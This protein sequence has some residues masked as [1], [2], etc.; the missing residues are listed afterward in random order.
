MHQDISNSDRTPKETPS[1]FISNHSSVILL[2]SSQC[3]KM[4]CK[5][6][7]PSLNDEFRHSLDLFLMIYLIQSCIKSPVCFRMSRWGWWMTDVFISH[8]VYSLSF[9][10]DIE[11]LC[12]VSW[13][14]RRT[15]LWNCERDQA[16]SV[17]ICRSARS[18]LLRRERLASLSSTCVTPTSQSTFSCRE[19]C[20]Q[21]LWLHIVAHNC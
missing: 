19:Q 17:E 1:N 6:K 7:A 15:L 18:V 2:L 5:L 9:T 10:G 13:L 8:R 14:N 4:C 16:F 11:R 12:L 21:L 3:S 20:P